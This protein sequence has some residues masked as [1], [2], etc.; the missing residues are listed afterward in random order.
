M[1]MLR[2]NHAKSEISMTNRLSVKEMDTVSVGI[3]SHYSK[4]SVQDMRVSEKI[5]QLHQA[6][7]AKKLL[8]ANRAMNQKV[9]MM[10]EVRKQKALINCRK[11]EFR[12]SKA[13][14]R[15]AILARDK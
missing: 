14:Q 15:K 2:P 11:S 10:Q 6:Q 12:I 4:L 1:S 3:Y 9:N 5:A 8:Q 7:S 13:Q